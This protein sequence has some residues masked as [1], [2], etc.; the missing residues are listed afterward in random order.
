MVIDII[1]YLRPIDAVRVK[2]ISKDIW[3]SG[4]ELGLILRED[5]T[6]NK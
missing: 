2:L 6:S 1:I 5:V 4:G 3:K